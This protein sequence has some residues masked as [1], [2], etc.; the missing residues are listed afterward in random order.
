MATQKT[1]AEKLAEDREK[2]RQLAIAFRTVLGKEGQR[3]PAQL[4]VWAQLE[5]MG[6]RRRTTLVPDAAG[7]LCELRGAVG[8]G[9]RMFF[10]Q[11]EELVRHAS[12]SEEQS[13]KPEVIK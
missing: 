9:H 1:Q 5:A 6:Y 10:L 13:T 12:A 11:I 3:S 8:E 7:Q 2:T 4:A